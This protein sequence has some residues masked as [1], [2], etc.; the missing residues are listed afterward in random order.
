MSL[1]T[2]V[3]KT[4]SA[5][6]KTLLREDPLLPRWLLRAIFD[7]H[8]SE[9]AI[10][11]EHG[12]ILHVNDAWRCFADQHGFVG[13][14]Y[15]V[16]VNYFEA[17]EATLGEARRDAKA[18]TE[19]FRRVMS[20]ELPEFCH[21]YQCQSEAA[22]RWFVIRAKRLASLVANSTL[23]VLVSHEDVSPVKKAEASL[24]VS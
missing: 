1:T 7:A 11:D 16:G 3:T 21:E 22:R 18:V 15:E 8:P 4:D 14:R 23:R 17:C 6:R 20:G 24:L 12:V 19:G 9:A 2:H 5:P 13:Q 10:L